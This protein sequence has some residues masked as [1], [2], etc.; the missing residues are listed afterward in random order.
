M[1]R[2]IHRFDKLIFISIISYQFITFYLTLIYKYWINSTHHYIFSRNL[3]GETLRMFD[4]LYTGNLF[5]IICFLISLVALVNIYLHF[6]KVSYSSL[7]IISLISLISIIIFLYVIFLGKPPKESFSEN[8]VS[9]SEKGIITVSALSFSLIHL[10][11]IVSLCVISFSALMKLYCWKSIFITLLTV[12]SGYLIVFMFC[13]NFK[14][15]YSTLLE[16]KITADA[17]TVLGAAVWGG[18]RPSPVLRERINKGYELYSK[19]IIRYIVLTGGGSPGEMTEAEVSKR[20][21]LKKGVK[22]QFILVENKS[23]STLEQISYLSKNVYRQNNWNL[24]VIISDNF[25]LLRTKQISRFFGL[26]IYTVSSDTP[27]SAESTFNFCIKESLAV[28]LFWLF[29]IG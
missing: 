18:N 13:Y 10:F 14:D 24:I 25:H 26:N 17:G 29:G 11:I 22:E 27:L 16:N 12:S 2:K 3:L 28:I 6:P 9:L 1:E 5:W 7:K 4:L 23:N 15:D 19:G 21:L 20:E 8:L